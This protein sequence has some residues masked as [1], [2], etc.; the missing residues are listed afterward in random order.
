M[1]FTVHA[2]VLIRQCPAFAESCLGS[3]ALKSKSACHEKDIV[4]GRE[5]ARI[6]WIFVVWLYTSELVR[7]PEELGEYESGVEERKHEPVARLAEEDMNVKEQEAWVDEDLVDLYLF[8][9]SHH[10]DTLANLGL[11]TLAEQS[12]KLRRT[13]SLP[14]VQRAYD[15]GHWA[16]MLR[17]ILV[18]EAER[19]LAR[20]KTPAHRAQSPPDYLSDILK[21]QLDGSSPAKN[22]TTW[23]SAPCRY[24]IHHGT[25]E[26]QECAKVWQ[27]G[28]PS[29]K[30]STA[31]YAMLDEPRT[32]L[33]GVNEVPIM[34]HKGLVEHHSPFFRGA[35]S[36]RFAEAQGTIKLPPEDGTVLL[37]TMH[38]L[39]TG[40]I[41]LPDA[42]ERRWMRALMPADGDDTSEIAAVKLEESAAET[43][44]LGGL[45]ESGMH[46]SARSTQQDDLLMLYV[47]AHRRQLQQLQ[48]AVM[49]RLVE[50]RRAEWAPMTSSLPRIRMA[51]DCGM[52]GTKLGAY[53]IDEAAWCWKTDL[54]AVN[55]L[56]DLPSDFLGPVVEAMLKKKQGESPPWLAQEPCLRYHERIDE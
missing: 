30:R 24:H 45:I 21:S 29:G 16:S 22:Y 14:A 32:M 2:G 1:R 52:I 13:T 38:W 44:A 54:Q 3:E 27:N 17:G 12:E 9:R 10:I 41:R 36:G 20:T 25:Q 56:S 26:Q 40:T 39:Y 28:G 18:E 37:M 42:E 34:V 48:D 46:G 15:T 33:V 55:A 49:T 7:P 50:L 31:L 23:H 11:S 5:D 51:C 47:T 43:D 19:R 53:L 8:S 4:L 35:F 6:F